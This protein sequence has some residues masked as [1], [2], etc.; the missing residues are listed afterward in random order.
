MEKLFETENFVLESDG[1]ILIG[2]WKCKII[3]LQIAKETIKRRAEVLAN[4]GKYPI[5]VIM[6][7]V[8]EVP[9]EVRKYLS[10]KENCEEF[11]RCGIVVNSRFQSMIANIFIKFTTPPVDTRMFLDVDSAK[12]WLLKNGY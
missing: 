12:K 2:T 4:K 1:E 10:L 5:L 11:S 6:D 7:E 8:D 9:I 3:D